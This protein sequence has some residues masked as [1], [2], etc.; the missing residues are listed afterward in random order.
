MYEKFYFLR[1]FAHCGD[2]KTRGTN[3]DKLINNCAT[4]PC[5]HGGSCSNGVGTYT[6]S[7]TAGYT[8]T[9]CASLVN[10]CASNP[11]QNG[12]NCTN[13]NGVSYT[14]TCATGYT[15]TNC[16]T[17]V[18][19]CT[20]NPCQHNGT[21]T[22]GIGSYTCSCPAGYTG[23]NCATVVNNCASAPCQ[24]GG[25]CTNRVNS[26]SCKCAAGWTGVNCNT[27]VNNCAFKP[28][29]HGGIC[30]NRLNAFNC[31][32]A[33]GYT[34]ALNAWGCCWVLLIALSCR[35]PLCQSLVNN[36][37]PNACLNGGICIN[38]VNSFTC[39]CAAGF[40]FLL[41]VCFSILFVTIDVAAAPRVVTLQSARPALSQF[42]AAT[43]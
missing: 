8:G 16:A 2:L 14:C 31:T 42:L 36:C 11:C 23:A 15:G 39:F 35:G 22:C 12:G 28:C 43:R 19:D 21:C 1:L 5:Q 40:R 41:F 38:G 4:N 30:I 37:A 25:V 17:L 34:Y 32:C 26:Y 6:C 24:N 18:D 7:C 13:I 20:P 29:K 10:T 3:C 33:A 9:N 27:L